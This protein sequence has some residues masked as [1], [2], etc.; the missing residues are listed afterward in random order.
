M[1]TSTAYTTKKGLTIRPG[2]Q[3]QDTRPSN[4]RTLLVDSLEAEYGETFALCIVTRQEYDGQVTE[5]MRPTKMRAD[6]LGG[7][8]FKRV[9]EAEQ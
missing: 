8:G 5:P 1:T 2:D 9:A 4:V 3:F 7:R 6:R